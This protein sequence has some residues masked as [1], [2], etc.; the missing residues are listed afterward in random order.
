MD[1]NSYSHVNNSC[2]TDEIASCISDDVMV[3]FE[4]DYDY[5]FQEHTYNVYDVLSDAAAEYGF[6]ADDHES[7]RDAYAK[8][9]EFY[10]S[11]VPCKN[12]I[13]LF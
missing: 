12:A 11:L 10:N 7:E 3:F 9:A 5:Y 8:A 6:I 2:N 4:H 13:P 1:C